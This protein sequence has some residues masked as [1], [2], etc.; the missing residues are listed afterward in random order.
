MIFD[1]ELMFSNKQALATDAVS[2]NTVRVGPG[3]AGMG[4]PISL[5]VCVA[6]AETASSGLTVELQTSDDESMAGAETLFSGVASKEKIRC[7][8]LALAVKLPRGCK[9]YLRL[10][11]SGVD[12]G[13]VT[14]G[15]VLDAPAA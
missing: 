12:A 4:E 8:G 15:L 7:G 1:S 13:T 2:E 11:Y 5:V 14:A 9:K 10:A 6:G 3:D